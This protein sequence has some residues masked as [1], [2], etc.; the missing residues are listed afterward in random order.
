MAQ[1]N[2]VPCYS[3]PGWL[4]YQRDVLSQLQNMEADSVH[5]VV[6]SPPYWGLR[7]YGVEGQIGLEDTI[8]QYVEKIVQVFE[9]VK[10]VLRSDGTLWLNMGDCYSGVGARDKFPDPKNL[11]ANIPEFGPNRTPQRGIKRKDLIGVPWRV[12]FALQASGWWLRSDIIW[13]KPN[14]MPES[15]TDRPTRAHEYLFLMAKSEDYYYNA[16]AIR[17]PF[18]PATKIRITQPGFD[19]QTGGPKDPGTGNRSHRKALRNLHTKYEDQNGTSAGANK[20]SVWEIPIFPCAE[21]HFATF[22][23]QLVTLCILAGCPEEGIVLDPFAGS[24]TVGIVALGLG[25]RFV[26]IELKEDY[27]MMAVKRL[28]ATPWQMQIP[29]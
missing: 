18:S 27:V 26:G 19:Q 5:C 29:V 6:T 20:R 25:R 3:G 15:V 12:A 11:H 21:A 23:K 10:R 8:D 4:L 2:C 13:S 7:D 1:H 28:K 22:P 24:G 16:D 17:E 9:L 14:P